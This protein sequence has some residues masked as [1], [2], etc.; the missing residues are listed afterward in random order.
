MSSRARVPATLS[1][2][3]E[4]FWLIEGVAP[5]GAVIA[6]VDLDD[7]PADELLAN[8]VDVVLM[9]HD[10]GTMTRKPVLLEVRWRNGLV[11]GCDPPEPFWITRTSRGFVRLAE[12]VAS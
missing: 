9:L 5:S 8:G 1:R 4:P 3:S 12:G 11:P 10:R 2:P 6:I 7:P